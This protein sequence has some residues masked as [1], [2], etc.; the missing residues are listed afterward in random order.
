MKNM[1]DRAYKDYIDKIEKTFQLG[2]AT[3]HSYRPYLMAWV[4]S[5]LPRCFIQNEP[6][7]QK[8][9][10][11]DL[12]IC[13]DSGLPVAFI[14]TKDIGHN[15]LEGKTVNKDQFDRYKDNL[16]SVIFTNYLDFYFYQNGQLVDSVSI[17]TLDGNC[18]AP[19]P[20]AVEKF[21]SLLFEAIDSKLQTIHSAS[22]LA[23][24][25]AQKAIMLA[26]AVELYLN[27]SELDKN[28]S[29]LF[30][31]FEA[32]RQ[33]LISTLNIN[34]FASI[35]AQTI[36][37]GLFA[38]R[39]YDEE[40]YDFS[41]YKV[42]YVIP[43][44]N[45]F[46]KGVF[47][48]LAGVYLDKNVVWIVNDMVAMFK[49][50]DV[51]QIMDSYMRQDRDP[52]VHFYEDFLNVYN[53]KE[54]DDMSVWYTPPAVVS[55]MVK[56]VNQILIKDFCISD[57][58]AHNQLVNFKGKHLQ[59]I[60]I[61][62]PATGTGTFLAEIINYIYD[63]YFFQK[64]EGSWQSFVS[65]CLIPRLNGFEI[66][67]AA[68]TIAHTKL[69]LILAKT[70]FKQKEDER[71]NI[72][73]TDSL[74]D[75]D[76]E[77]DRFYNFWLSRESRA[78]KHIKKDTP[79]MILLGN[80]PYKGNSL[81]NGPWIKN[82]ILPYK[83]EPD[84][85]ERLK[86]ANP[87]WLNADYVKFIRLGQYFIEKDGIGQGVLAYINPHSYLDGPTFRG[88]RWHL[89]RTFDK[90]YVIDLH[91]NKK[92]GEATN[93]QKDDQNVF[94]IQQGVCINIFVKTGL[95]GADDLGTVYYYGDTYGKRRE[96]YMFLY[97]HSI[98]DI[99][100]TII[101]PKGNDY[102]F[103]PSAYTEKL[104]EQ[105]CKGFSVKELF[106]DSSVG[107]VTTK[108]SFLICDSKEELKR[109]INELIVL[110]ESE[111]Q[112]KYHIND[113]RDWSVKR[114]KDDIGLK[115]NESKI[116]PI[117]YR[118][119][120]TRYTYY[121]GKTNGII[122]WPRHAVMKTLIEG[123]NVALITCRQIKSAN[124][125]HAVIA[126]HIV[127][128]SR[129]SNKSKERSYVFPLYRKVVSGGTVRNVPNFNKDILYRISS[130]LKEDVNPEE[131]FNYTYGCL[132]LPSYLH[133]YNELLKED[134]PRVPYPTDASQY[135]EIAHYGQNRRS[136]LSS[137]MVPTAFLF[138][139][140]GS[141][142]IDTFFFQPGKDGSSGRIYINDRQYFDA[143]DADI[144]SYLEGGFQPAFQWLKDR[145]KRNNK[146]TYDDII[147]YRSI[148]TK[149]S[150][151]IQLEENF[152][153]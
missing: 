136:I 143:V 22:R 89:L 54:K 28:N 2:T 3:E 55:F 57:G 49:A 50:T 26:Q 92:T 98:D 111:F 74:Q 80:P 60:Q 133:T 75:P 152:Q 29:L 112:Q 34:S 115:F 139:V 123:D 97:S 84:S 65:N 142:T 78:A 144:W 27:D 44:S 31:Q 72:Y 21:K 141:D 93:T 13:S 32:I 138:P 153:L 45:P 82:L 1:A 113:S 68:Y 48:D 56:S 59:R 53:P 131:L 118:P 107:I 140:A 16:T 11:P 64:N 134:F 145:K 37:Y 79:L 94:N 51:K 39:L 62:D 106:K 14:E 110:K 41:R 88:M 24:L 40:P 6:K 90:I 12:M 109:H 9:G 96:K 7:R 15:D 149:I 124:W 67:M 69:N 71:F 91:G 77:K 108:D 4:E 101:E 70:G 35:Y 66:L 150:R 116:Q 103:V 25:M 18:I 87:K 86:E 73:L 30:N 120:D 119:F 52:L 58:L 129:I 121:T 114:A 127:D 132:S 85:N 104:K 20:E 5:A 135:H 36:V 46:L 130:I 23:Q 126:T 102:N 83:Y 61:L 10:A 63:Q 8:F 100:F 148:L 81:N 33:S 125:H 151:L 99:S 137:D 147:H 95:K 128:D 146:L 105:Y 17:G 47:N 38:A 117:D 76:Y 122:A 42:P 43:Q 19:N